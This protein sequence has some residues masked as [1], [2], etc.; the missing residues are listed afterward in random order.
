MRLMIVVERD[1]QVAILRAVLPNE[2]LSVCDMYLSGPRSTLLSFAR[3][4]LVKYHR[5]LAVL[6]DTG[7]LDPSVTVETIS[8]DR[9]ESQ[10][11]ADVASG[12]PFKVV[13]CIPDLEALFFNGSIDLKRIFPNYDEGVYLMF[14]KTSS[15]RALEALFKNGGGPKDLHQLL[16]HLTSEDA[17]RLRGTYPINQLMEFIDDLRIIPAKSGV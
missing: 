17:E 16:D 3:T 5:P 12:T 6:V 15:K 1:A 14:A 8:T 13:Y 11:L 9:L 4:L 10:L 2:I 7:S